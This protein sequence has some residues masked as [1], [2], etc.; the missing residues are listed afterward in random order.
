MVRQ[1]LALACL[2]VDADVFGARFGDELLDLAQLHDLLAD[3][4]GVF[5]DELGPRVD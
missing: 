4:V 1:G 3:G 2:G 5:R